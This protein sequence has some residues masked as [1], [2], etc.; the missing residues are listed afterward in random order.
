MP[1]G[2]FSIDFSVSAT[3]L[4]R[5]LRTRA[6]TARPSTEGVASIPNVEAFRASNAAS[7]AAMSSFEGMQPTLAHVVP[8]K[9]SSISTVLR[10]GFPRGALSS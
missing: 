3:N 1:A 7:A 2:S 9:R 5:S 8:A 6:M 10:S 4:S